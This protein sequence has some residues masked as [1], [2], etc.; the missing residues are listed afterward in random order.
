MNPGGREPCGRRVLQRREGGG[1]K[2]QRQL[3]GYRIILPSS[4]DEQ[5]Y[6]NGFRGIA[7]DVASGSLRQR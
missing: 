7:A 6:R 2:R 4:A 3:P 5:T 1:R